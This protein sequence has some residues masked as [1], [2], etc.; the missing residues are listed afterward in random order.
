MDIGSELLD[1]IDRD[2]RKDPPAPS[3][4]RW[5]DRMLGRGQDHD[6][7]FG[8]AGASNLDDAAG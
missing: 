2:R 8:R 6:H 1:Q 5:I 4:R 7:H 3:E